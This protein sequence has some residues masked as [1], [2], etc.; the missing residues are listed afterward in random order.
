MPF[1]S[2]VAA[3]DLAGVLR[4]TARVA[5]IASVA[6]ALAV[7]VVV[8]LGVREPVRDWYGLTPERPVQIGVWEL[9]SHNA[10]ALLLAF[11]A[12]VAVTWWPRAR[13]ALDVA[14]ALVFGANVV[15]VAVALGAYGEPL[16]HLGPGHYPLEL[17]AL[18]TASAAYL[19]ARRW[20]V[21]RVGATGTAAALTALALLLAAI[22]ES[23]GAV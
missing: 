8:L 18:A 21:L 1:A 9:W 15:L 11:A 14:L 5:L 20:G 13:R 16:V 6:A 4:D 17:L 19:D 12:A 10:R 22:L 7:A 2:S 23:A 3:R